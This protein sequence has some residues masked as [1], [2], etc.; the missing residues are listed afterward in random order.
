[1][2]FSGSKELALP[3]LPGDGDL[4][5]CSPRF[6]RLAHL[7]RVPLFLGFVACFIF[8]GTGLIDGIGSMS[9]LSLPGMEVLTLRRQLDVGTPSRS[10]GTLEPRDIGTPSAQE[11]ERAPTR[12][13][14]KGT[15]PRNGTFQVIPS[16]IVGGFSAAWFMAKPLTEVTTS[17][18]VHGTVFGL[19]FPETLEKPRGGAGAT[20]LVAPGVNKCCS[21]LLNFT[22][23][24]P[25]W[26][27]SSRG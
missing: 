23:R 25:G 9:V 10:T 11:G 22:L 13:Q 21:P 8:L 27:P 14:A 6:I 17:W 12:E 15:D 1:M 26:G 7:R 3:P 20:K 5:T 18:V 4:I 2:N 19:S 16:G 24:S